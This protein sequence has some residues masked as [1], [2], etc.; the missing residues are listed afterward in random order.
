LRHAFYEKHLGS[1]RTVLFEDENKHGWMFGFTENYIKVKHPWNPDWVN[2]LK[3]MK[4]TEL[5][6]DGLALA[7]YIKDV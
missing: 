5:D 7:S 6:E 2:T 4:L 3:T 1:T